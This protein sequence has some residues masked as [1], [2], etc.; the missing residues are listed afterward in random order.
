MAKTNQL[1]FR[2][3]EVDVQ[4]LFEVV[5][6]EGA[7]GTGHLSGAIPVAVQSGAV[8]I[9][10]GKL[11]GQAGL[12]RLRSEA[13]AN[14]LAGGGE[15]AQLLLD[16]LQNFQYDQ[17]TL[18]AE[19][20]FDGESVIRLH[21]EGRNPDVLEGRRFRINLNLTGNLDRLTRSLLEIARL[22]DRAVRAT[23]NAVK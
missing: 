21:L 17:L 5:G 16:A 18:T 6:L 15:S 9:H 14:L 12:L 4:R 2:F 19:K 11:I 1:E 20:S 3:E 13:A 7:S 10:E 8:A 22:S 23:M